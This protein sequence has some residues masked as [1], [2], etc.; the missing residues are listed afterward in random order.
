[1][2][3]PHVR[4]DLSRIEHNARCIVR[5]CAEHGIGVTGVTKG[6][7][8]SP[9]V[10]RAMLRGGCASIGDSRLR[11]VERHSQASSAHVTAHTD[12]THVTL[13][14][15]DDGEGFEPAE[16][17]G[18]LGLQSMRERVQIL[19]GRLTIRSRPGDGTRIE[20]RIPLADGSE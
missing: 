18:G 3:Q 13:S 8:G 2:A 16:N 1:M 9:E 12:E 6:T 19:D 10:A 5:V 17:G 14:V 7:C 4:I 11:N 20:A 15:E